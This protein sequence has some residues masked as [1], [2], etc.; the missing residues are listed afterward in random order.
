M[1][2]LKRALTNIKDETSHQGVVKLGT[3]LLPALLDNRPLQD[4]QPVQQSVR[5]FFDRLTL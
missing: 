5:W 1:R 2:L 4:Y 3:K